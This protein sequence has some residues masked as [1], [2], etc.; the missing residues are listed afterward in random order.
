MT[1]LTAGNYI[2]KAAGDVTRTYN[3]SADQTFTVDASSTNSP[4]KVVL[5]NSSGNFNARIIYATLNGTATRVSNSLSFDNDII[6]YDPTNTASAYSSYDGDTSTQINFDATPGTATVYG[7]NRIAARN[8]NGD[9]W[10]NTGTFNRI[11]CSGT[12]TVSDDILIRNPAYVDGGTEP[13][14][15]S[16]F[17]KANGSIDNKSYIPIST[18]SNAYG[19][20]YV[21]TTEPSSP[22]N[23]DIWYE[24]L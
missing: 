3:G 2:Q 8:S 11:T 14:Y 13:L 18:D 4:D 19:K 6:G 17:M 23:G 16:G 9:I 7:Q 22:S 24:I 10:G 12:L 21:Q 5:R 20:R 15:L 1:T